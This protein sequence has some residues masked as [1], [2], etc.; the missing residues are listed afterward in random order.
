[1]PDIYLQ[2]IMDDSVIKAYPQ[3]CYSFNSTLWPNKEKNNLK[4]PLT[5]IIVCVII[6]ELQQLL[7]IGTNYNYSQVLNNH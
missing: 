1:M 7:M 4:T 3:S 2:H 6:L 5:E